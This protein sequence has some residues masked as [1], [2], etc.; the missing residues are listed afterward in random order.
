MDKRGY[1]NIN[2]KNIEQASISTDEIRSILKGDSEKLIFHAQKFS[3]K[4]LKGQSTASIRKIFT[5]IKRMKK[6][7]KYDL[8]LMRAKLAYVSKRDKGLAS[9]ADLLDQM[10]REVKEDSF[11]YFQDFFESIVAYFYKYGKE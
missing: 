2:K 11:K 10:I 5:E 6:Y 9:L 1:K 3:E 7:N 8:D 4:N